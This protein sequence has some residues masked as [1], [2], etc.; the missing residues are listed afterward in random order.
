MIPQFND[1]DCVLLVDPEFPTDTEAE[2]ELLAGLP[3]LEIVVVKQSVFD[4]MTLS[5]F[6]RSEEHTSELQSPTTLFP[7][8]TLFRSGRSRVACWT[9][10]LGNCRCQTVRV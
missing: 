10:V 8:P 2:A 3:F 7:Y 1:I 6:A 9:A 5:F 4:R